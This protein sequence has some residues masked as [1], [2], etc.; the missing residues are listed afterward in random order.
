MPIRHAFAHE[1]FE[2]SDVDGLLTR[3]SAQEAK[4]REFGR[5]SLA[6]PSGRADEHISIGVYNSM[7][8]LG[9]HRV[10]VREPKDGLKASVAEGALWEWAKWQEFGVSWTRRRKGKAG[11]SDGNDSFDSKP[12]IGESTDIVG[13]RER[14]K[15]RSRECESLRLLSLPLRKCPQF[16]V[17]DVLCVRVLDPD[18]P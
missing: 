18:P 13:R 4:E 14:L 3:V 17:I 11:E 7:K 2:R 1:R 10:E 12:S 8:D 16:L 15:E 5:D 9:L 6:R